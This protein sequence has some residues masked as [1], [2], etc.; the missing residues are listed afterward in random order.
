MDA[1]IREWKPGKCPICGMKLVPLDPG[2]CVEY[3]VDMKTMPNPVR[4]GQPAKFTFTIENPRTEATVV[5]FETVH[6][7]QF[8]LF[9]VS[10][11]MTFFEH[12]HPEMLK[13]GALVIHNTLTKPAPYQAFYVFFPPA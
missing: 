11:D 12:I 1:K 4:A 6:E 3:P 7:R 2:E 5:N 9:I 13:N 10:H 8:H